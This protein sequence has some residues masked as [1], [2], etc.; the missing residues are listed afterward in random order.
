MPE[1]ELRDNPDK[2]LPKVIYFTDSFFVLYIDRK[3]NIFFCISSS[4]EV[5]PRFASLCML[6]S[7]AYIIQFTIFDKLASG[8]FEP[9]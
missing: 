6:Q 3:S 1:Y 9:E 7:S 2:T 8:L 4:I 5:N